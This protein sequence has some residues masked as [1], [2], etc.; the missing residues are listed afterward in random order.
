M[1]EGAK[2]PSK[3]S[4]KAK[5]VFEA[6]IAK[7]IGKA[8]LRQY[9]RLAFPSIA[10]RFVE[11]ELQALEQKYPG[12]E[13]SREHLINK[14]V[15]PDGQARADTFSAHNKVAAAQLELA[16]AHNKACLARKAIED[17]ASPEELQKL[18]LPALLD[19]G[20]GPSHVTPATCHVGDANKRQKIA[21][22]DEAA[23]AALVD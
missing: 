6:C 14:L 20:A 12:L 5:D 11:S 23:A 10:R 1:K 15:L 4:M 9:Q 17:V 2:R 13:R 7:S 3:I 22:A 16:A 19:S 8:T 18:K 21:D